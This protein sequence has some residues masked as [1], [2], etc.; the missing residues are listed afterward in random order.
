[1]LTLGLAI[2]VNAVVFSFINFFVL[3]PLPMPDPSRVV[4]VFAT[5]AERA[6]DRQGVASGDFL[7]WSQETRTLD[8]LAAFTHH[9]Q[10]HGDGRAPAR[11]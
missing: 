6:R 8:H 3:R 1:V 5:H 4:L 7:E 9:P 11:T 10:P 2:G